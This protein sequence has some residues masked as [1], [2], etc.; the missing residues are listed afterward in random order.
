MYTNIRTA[1]YNL[2]AAFDSNKRADHLYG[3]VC[4][5]MSGL[6]LSLLNQCL[7]PMTLD[8]LLKR[9]D[10]RGD[11]NEILGKFFSLVHAEI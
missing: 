6:E 1:L 3:E 4:E 2:V 11:Q 5:E 8:Q 7:G 10:E 9:Y